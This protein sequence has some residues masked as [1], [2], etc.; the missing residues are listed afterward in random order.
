VWSHQAGAPRI[1]IPAS[2]SGS[3]AGGEEKE[4]GQEAAPPVEVE[5]DSGRG[6]QHRCG[7][8]RQ[9][10]QSHETACGSQPE[11]AQKGCEQR[12]GEES[13]DQVTSFSAKS[14]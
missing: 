13:K 2:D 10:Q 8:S 4:K 11:L 1:S 3:R 9:Q 6:Q 5:V 14:A 12:G 7:H